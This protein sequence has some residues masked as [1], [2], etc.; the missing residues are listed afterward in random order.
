MKIKN[1]LAS[2]AVILSLGITSVAQADSIGTARLDITNFQWNIV[3]DGVLSNITTNN[4]HVVISPAGNNSGNLFVSLDGATDG[5]GINS[6]LIPGGGAIGPNSV[7]VG[8]CV[9]APNGAPPTAT[10]VYASHELNG[11]IVDL[12]VN[13]DNIADVTGGANAFASAESSL[14]SNSNLANASS[15]LGTNTAF[16]FVFDG[17][18]DVDTTLDFDYDVLA[19]ASVVNPFGIS[20]TATA[21]TGWNLTITDLTDNITALFWNPNE[22]NLSAGVGAG[23]ADAI[24]AG[25]GDLSNSITLIGGHEYRFAITHQLTT[26]ATRNVNNVPEPS[27]LALLGIGLLGFIGK[28]SLNRKK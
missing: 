26:S 24:F 1:I 4:P 21:G 9:G 16:D 11:A 3:G 19:L 25:V 28:G 22:L 20:D 27:L 7:C 18:G 13:G 17:E 14:I 10:Y 15:N 8:S 5:I 23:D 2:S 6:P 12:D